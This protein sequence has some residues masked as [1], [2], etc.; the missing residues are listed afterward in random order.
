[1]DTKATND[2]SDTMLCTVNIKGDNIRAQSKDEDTALHLAARAGDVMAVQTLLENGADA[3][4]KNI[5][6]DTALHLAARAGNVMV[7]QVLL[8]KGA[9]TTIINK[10][11]E[12]VL[13]AVLHM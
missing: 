2:A 5:N 13:D 12:T 1:M 9:D 4:A 7:A 6:G 8:K 10:G 3:N 11:E